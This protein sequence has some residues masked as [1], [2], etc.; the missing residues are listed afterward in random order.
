MKLRCGGCGCQ[1]RPW[2][3]MYSWTERG[4]ADWLCEDCFDWRFG[5]L[6]REEKAA[7]LGCQVRFGE[8]AEAAE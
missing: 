1:I 3:R 5:E 4:Y 7:L 8:D 6:T 2:E